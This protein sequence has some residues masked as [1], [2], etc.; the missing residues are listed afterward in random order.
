MPLYP[1]WSN[2]TLRLLCTVAAG[3]LIG[4]DRGEHGRPAGL[5][6]TMLVSL[7]A[8]LA[9]LQANVLLSTTGKHPDSFV[10]FDV[11][12]LPLGILSG[13]GF[14]GAG[15]IVRR[16]NLVLGVTTAATLWFITVVGLCFGGGQF[17]LG[18]SGLVLGLLIIAGLRHLERHI[19]QD[20]EGRLTVVTVAGGPNED[21][22]RNM[23]ITEHYT[24][25]TFGIVYTAGIE[26]KELNC[27]INWRG[28]ASDLGVP[29]VVHKLGSHPG[30]LKIEWSPQAR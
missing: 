21:E 4:L 26:Q 6:T 25:K 20:R 12:R 7:A 28:E 30:V 22:V 24:I 11:M 27:Q 23:L 17:A 10:N 16:D 3:F 2:I 29:P 5:R 9:M 15:A 18:F 19:K 14:I 13:M 8:C 1:E